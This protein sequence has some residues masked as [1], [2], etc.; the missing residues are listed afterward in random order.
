MTLEVRINGTSS[1]A[2]QQK[3]LN[4]LYNILTNKGVEYSKINTVFTARE[5]NSF[6]LRS[7]IQNNNTGEAH[8]KNINQQSHQHIQ[9]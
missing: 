7:I 5:P 3:R 4:L 2:L 8:Q 1:T 6:I 9:W